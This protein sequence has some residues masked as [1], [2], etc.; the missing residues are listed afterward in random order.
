MQKT[1]AIGPIVIVFSDDSK[2]SDWPMVKMTEISPSKDR[3]IRLV[4]VR[5]KFG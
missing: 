3:H 1:F 4:K 2:R 5:M